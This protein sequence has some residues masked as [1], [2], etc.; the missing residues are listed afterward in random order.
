MNMK[1]IGADTC[2]ADARR[3]MLDMYEHC[4]AT[5]RGIRAWEGGKDNGLAVNM[6]VKARTYADVLL[7]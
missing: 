3:I 1:D 5:G 2:L 4:F 6:H 7:R